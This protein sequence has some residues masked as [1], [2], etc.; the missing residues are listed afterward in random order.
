[1]LSFSKLNWLNPKIILTESLPYGR[2]Q[3]VN[4][5]VAKDEVLIVFGG[6]VMTMEEFYRLPPEIQEFPYQISENP[7]LVLGPA[8]F[9]E[10]QNGEFFNHSC[11]PNTGFKTE[12]HLVAMRDI[13]PGEELTF[14][15]AMCT[16]GNFGDMECS[17]GAITCRGIIRSEDWK[18]KALQVKYEGY[19]MPYIAGKIEKVRQGQ[20]KCYTL[21]MKV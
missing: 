2:G 6:H 14:D 11:E 18:L 20:N 7:D 17:C 12:I 1:M 9:E 16:T 5:H 13:R 19:F 10:L 15:Y 3:I 21:K 8:N 4:D